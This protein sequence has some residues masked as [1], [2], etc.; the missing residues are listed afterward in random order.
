[1]EQP[2]HPEQLRGRSD[3]ELRIKGTVAPGQE[4]TTS[5]VNDLLSEVGAALNYLFEQGREQIRISDA[6]KKDASEM[7]DQIAC[8]LLLREHVCRWDSCSRQRFLAVL[9]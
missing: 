8:R 5:D 6:V 1:M 4:K 7:V 3:L 9:R 2:E